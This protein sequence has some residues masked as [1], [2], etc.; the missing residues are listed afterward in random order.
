MSN[1]ESLY[2]CIRYDEK[3]IRILRRAGLTEVANRIALRDTQASCV[4][5]RKKRLKLVDVL[6]KV[7]KEDCPLYFITIIPE[8]NFRVKEEKLKKVN[9]TL[10]KNRLSKRIYRILKDFPSTV[11]VGGLDISLIRNKKNYYDIH[12]H[13]LFQCKN[14]DKE[15]LKKRFYKIN[16]KS[17]LLFPIK[18]IRVKYTR[19]D[20]AYVYSYLLKSIFYYRKQFKNLKGNSIVKRSLL[21]SRNKK[22]ILCLLDKYSVNDRL[23][24]KNVDHKLTYI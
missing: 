3:N 8:K 4:F 21:P 5:M 17:S 2:S 24:F 12:L 13:G 18:I 1:F 14:S 7:F 9:L 19:E 6:N 10:L 22:E 20:Y 16:Q 23:I 11:F 15:E